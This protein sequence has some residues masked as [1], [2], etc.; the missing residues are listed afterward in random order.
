MRPE[1]AGLDAVPADG[2][3]GEG[4]GARATGG[5]HA[6]G[7]ADTATPDLALGSG[8]VTRSVAGRVPG[9]AD[10]GA[11]VAD[12]VAGD[13]DDSDDGVTVL[14]DDADAGVV[15]GDADD[16][17]VVGEDVMA[18]GAE[19]GRGKGGLSEPGKGH[20][21]V[22]AW[23]TG[24]GHS[25]DSARYKAILL[26]PG[27]QFPQAV[28]AH[29]VH[30][31]AG[32]LDET[33]GA[34]AARGAVADP[35]WGVGERAAVEAL[36]GRWVRPDITRRWNDGEWSVVTAARRS[37]E[38]T[39]AAATLQTVIRYIPADLLRNYRTILTYLHNR[40]EDRFVAHFV[41]AGGDLVAAGVDVFALEWAATPLVQRAV[42]EALVYRGL[43][44]SDVTAS[45]T[46]G[47]WGAVV[48]ALRAS[49]KAAAATILRLAENRFPEVFAEYEYFEARAA[50]TGSDVPGAVAR[51]LRA[52]IDM[53]ERGVDVFAL[54][55]M[56]RSVV[57]Q[58]LVAALVGYRLLDQEHT[59][60]WTDSDWGA[61]AVAFRASRVVAEATIR[62]LATGGL[63]A[64]QLLDKPPLATPSNDR[65]AAA[66]RRAADPDG[67]Q[68]SARTEKLVAAF[69]E[70][71]RAC[72]NV[73][74]AGVADTAR[75]AARPVEAPHVAAARLVEAGDALS[76]EG[77]DVFAVA[78]TRLHGSEEEADVKTLVAG[79]LP[80][81]ST[82]DWTGREWGAVA[83]ARR[84]GEKAAIAAAAGASKKVEAAAVRRGGEDLAAATTWRV[85][86]DRA[87]LPVRNISSLRAATKRELRGMRWEGAVDVN[88]AMVAR[89]YATLTQEEAGTNER[90]VAFAIAGRIVSPGQR[91]GLP[92]GAARLKTFFRRARTGEDTKAVSTAGVPVVA[93]DRGVN[94]ASIP[95]T[96]GSSRPDAG[97]ELMGKLERT[98]GVS[99]NSSLGVSE[100]KRRYFDL[101]PKV[102]DPVK[103]DK[104]PVE[105][106]PLIDQVWMVRTGSEH[107]DVLNQEILGAALADQVPG[108]PEYERL[109]RVVNS[110]GPGWA[111][112]GRPAGGGRL[113]SVPAGAAAVTAV[114]AV[115][116]GAAVGEV[117]G[118]PAG[119][120]AGPVLPVDVNRLAPGAA[121][122]VGGVPA[123]GFVPGVAGVV[124]ESAGPELRPGLGGVAVV[125][126]TPMAPASVLAPASEV[127]SGRSG[128]NET[129][130]SFRRKWVK[131]PNE[132]T[133]PN[134]VQAALL[135]AYQIVGRY[136][137]VPMGGIA[138]RLEEH[139][140]NFSELPPWDQDTVLVAHRLLEQ[141]LED[142][143]EL[144]DFAKA[145]SEGRLKSEF[146]TML[147]GGAPMARLNQIQQ[148]AYRAVDP[149]MAGYVIRPPLETTSPG[150]DWQQAL[151]LPRTSEGTL[152][153]AA[154]RLMLQYSN[155][156]FGINRALIEEH[157]GITVD[158]RIVD[159]MR[160][161]A[162]P[163]QVLAKFPEIDSFR[164]QAGHSAS[165]STV[166]LDGRITDRNTRFD[167]M[168]K[169][170]ISVGRTPVTV[171]IDP[172]DS[173]DQTDRRLHQLITAVDMVQRAGYKV[174][175]MKI[176]FPKYTQALLADSEMMITAD[177]NSPQYLRSLY[178]EFIAPD[179]F[180]LSPRLLEATIDR[181]RD[182][183]GIF[184][185]LALQYDDSATAVIIHEIGHFL[186]YRQNPSRFFEFKTKWID[187]REARALSAYA[188]TPAEYPAE[189]FLGAVMGKVFTSRQSA[190]YAAV[191][192]PRPDFTPTPRP[193]PQL[194]FDKL[195]HLTQDVNSLLRRRGDSQGAVTPDWVAAEFQL[196]PRDVKFGYR[197]LIAAGLAD[198]RQ[199]GTVGRMLDGAHAVTVADHSSAVRRGSS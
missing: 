2:A 88:D 106:L 117:A 152:S 189:Y 185:G 51:L 171:H 96:L 180:I 129:L 174:P 19:A 73:D 90:A 86:A 110:Y 93:A 18:D 53:A 165:A 99:F 3:R 66:R 82:T 191:G 92:G 1:L 98:Y 36:A 22:S 139:D 70:Y 146:R 24:T 9:T 107:A 145:L 62:Q 56:A 97:A 49:E 91:L 77:V 13:T 141:P 59:T 160:G 79:W 161:R 74:E 134:S 144:E 151:I 25:L 80:G 40:F 42:V 7:I 142:P 112:G 163:S 173:R 17:T 175:D 178:A 43:S 60:R 34:E 198:V 135:A 85:A 87:G 124:T 41:R 127:V 195:A 64:L 81:G 114:T 10:E 108:T 143:K 102:I 121:G 131:T 122:D 137:R 35:G 169:L 187:A 133:P 170:D 125:G 199:Y 52:G 138:A 76:A 26:D 188:G 55:W 32:G 113:P 31:S 150:S 156:L 192:G 28:T 16:A 50:L 95:A 184:K 149:A 63:A 130:E 111:A 148:A 29:P 193:A 177:V 46:G 33:S 45:W 6:E 37:G 20:D 116:G 197:E 167:D 75:D 164:H 181:R 182:S 58:R 89:Y 61:V 38:A 47:D 147:V 103:V 168:A 155:R 166:V 105:W 157:A 94:T 190:M 119:E 186:Q 101:P 118:V 5:L 128:R 44:G 176:Y 65:L 8:V 132:G 78:W 57:E 115:T 67:R 153:P 71:Y 14:G 12:A 154:M 120:F 11:E 109:E 4:E 27:S 140:E 159:Q 183:D 54:E 158:L 15:G 104:F 123:G 179:R 69:E 194:N 83:V 39:A 136:Q 30:I 48:V 84:T 162:I 72:G 126:D 68:A 172:T 196:L 100:F 23:L 21:K